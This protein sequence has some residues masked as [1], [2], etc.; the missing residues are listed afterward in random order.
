M[1]RKKSKKNGFSLIELLVSIALGSGALFIL[2]RSLNML[3]AGSKKTD[4]ISEINDIKSSVLGM[5][6]CE[7]TFKNVT[8]RPAC[9]NPGSYID[10]LGKPATGFPNGRP[11]I[12]AN[13][14]RYGSWTVRAL[15]TSSGLD[16]RAAMILKP[17]SGETNT[18]TDWSSL[19]APSAENSVKYV[20]DHARDSSNSRYSWD[21]PLA[22]ITNPDTLGLCNEFFS[23]TANTD[24]G[25]SD[26][27]YLKQVNLND[28]SFECSED[29]PSCS[30]PFA[31]KLFKID[32]QNYNLGCSDELY[33]KIVSDISGHLPGAYGEVTTYAN[34]TGTDLNTKADRIKNTLNDV[35]NPAN[36][37]VVSG[38]SRRKCRSLS[39]MQCQNGWVMTSYEFRYDTGFS[40]SCSMNCRKIA[41]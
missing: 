25:C 41:P 23:T 17:F 30:P 26:R 2:G 28:G 3:N 39:D 8:A 27:Q 11:I 15:C 16:I 37:Y 13:G 35:F 38:D 1:R 31:L 29:I 20:K 33:N 18:L 40:Q 4:A 14:S 36:D 34:N 32:D 5:T 10:I 6:S 7:T 9:S 22:K 19:S 21:H 24:I 12:S